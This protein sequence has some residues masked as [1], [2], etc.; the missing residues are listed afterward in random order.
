MTKKIYWIFVFLV[1]VSSVYGL[2]N[3]LYLNMTY[4]ISQVLSQVT[5]LGNLSGLDSEF[6]GGINFNSGSQTKYIN[7]SNSNTGFSDLD[8]AGGDDFTIGIWFLT[9]NNGT[10]AQLFGNTLAVGNQIGFGMVNGRMAG[11]F[12]DG[13]SVKSSG[14]S[15]SENVWHF[16]SLVKNGSNIETY[17][18]GSLVSGF[19]NTIFSSAFI[20]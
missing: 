14:G 5:Y 3:D 8:V 4:G 6:R 13:S 12:N 18:D 9:L 15:I 16:G 20:K 7:L 2:N 17:L 11:G 10:N 19:T 1:L